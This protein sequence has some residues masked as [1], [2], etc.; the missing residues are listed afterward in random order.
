MMTQG[1]EQGMHGRLVI[2]EYQM[3]YVWLYLFGFA[4]EY[5]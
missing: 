5:I 2:A 3:V 1:K 4:W